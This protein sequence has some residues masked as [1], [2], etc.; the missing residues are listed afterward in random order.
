MK[1]CHFLDVRESKHL[2]FFL[3]NSGS[4]SWPYI[5]LLA[6]GPNLF[7][8]SFLQFSYSYVIHEL[9][10]FTKPSILLASLFLVTSKKSVRVSTKDHFVIKVIKAKQNKTA[11]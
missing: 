3:V 11:K 1:R 5:F 10:V 2:A 6:S 4:L 7:C 9:S 8:F